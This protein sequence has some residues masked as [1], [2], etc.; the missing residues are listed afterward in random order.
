M[1]TYYINQI[2]VEE[3][4]IKIVDER[5]QPRD[6]RAYDSDVAVFFAGPDGIVRA[7]GGY[8]YISMSYKGYVSYEF[9]NISPFTVAGDYKIQL[10][11]SRVEVGELVHYDLTDIATLEVRKGLI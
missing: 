11:L 10:K 8:G 5:R 4:L 9:G 2:P 1:T 6:L 7:G 3:L